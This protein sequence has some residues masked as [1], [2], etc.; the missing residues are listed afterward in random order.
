MISYRKKNIY[1][2]NQYLIFCIICVYCEPSEG[3]F[4]FKN[5]I[6]DYRSK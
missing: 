1:I 4:F 6:N 2:S 5:E 3:L